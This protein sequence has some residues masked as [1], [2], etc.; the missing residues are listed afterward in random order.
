MINALRAAKVKQPG[1][2]VTFA[3]AMEC[4]SPIIVLLLP[5]S[6]LPQVGD[7]SKSY[8]KRKEPPEWVAPINI[9]PLTI[10]YFLLEN[11]PANRTK[12]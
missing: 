3:E 8:W 10:L 6:T 11:Q 1:T 12:K 2:I 4:L 9:V 5:L 7:A